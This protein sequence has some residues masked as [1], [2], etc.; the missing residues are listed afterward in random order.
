MISIDRFTEE[1]REIY[2]NVIKNLQENFDHASEYAKKRC[3][4]CTGKGYFERD[5]IIPPSQRIVLP[6]N[7][8]VESQEKGKMTTKVVGHKV[9]RTSKLQRLLCSCVEKT[10]EKEILA[11]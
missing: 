10:V 8:A 9:L 7:E 2:K 5:K 6:I 3:S 4:Q 1:Q 11:L